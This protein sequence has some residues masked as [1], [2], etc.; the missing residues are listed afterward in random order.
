VVNEINSGRN[1]RGLHRVRVDWGGRTAVISHG[2]EGRD[3]VATPLGHAYIVAR[4]RSK[5]LEQTQ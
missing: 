5:Y 2:F 3:G 1:V 4:Y